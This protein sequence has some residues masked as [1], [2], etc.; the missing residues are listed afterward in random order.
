M[1][2]RILIVE[3]EE[4]LAVGISYNL[5]AEGFEVEV[6]ADGPSALEYLKKNRGVVG[7]VILDLM[8]PG[9]SGYEV[10]ESLRENDHSMPVLILSARTQPED[11]SRSFD[12]GAD[13]YLTKPFDLDELISRIRSLLQ[14][15]ERRTRTASQERLSSFDFGDA[16]IDFENS[17][18][19][20]RGKPVHMT[21][22][23]FKLLEYF[24]RHEGRVIPRGELLV[25]VWDMPASLNTRAGPVHPAA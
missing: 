8:L 3:D 24:A 14:R 25:Q 22:L 1:A 19:T 23:E 4:H 20:I 15:H 2:V 16:E 7:L 12:A 9:M 5:K 10:L 18:A 21:Q 11:R 17:E 13:Q 6:A